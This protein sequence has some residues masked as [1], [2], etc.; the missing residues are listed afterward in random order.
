MN[1]KTIILF[2]TM[3][4]SLHFAQKIYEIPSG[5]E[6]NIIQLDVVNNAQI[7]EDQIMIKLEERPDWVDF[8][9]Q[10]IALNNILETANFIFDIKKDAVINEES[11]LQFSVIKNGQFLGE[12]RITIKVIPPKDF[13]LYQNYPNPFNPTTTIEYS[14]PANNKNNTVDIKIVIF[15]ILGREVVTIVNQK[16]KPGNYK[17]EFNAAS[18]AGGLSSGTY[19][20]R[21]ISGDFSKTMKLV[22]LK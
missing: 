4:S 6:G 3:F 18:L 5:S 8:K 17:V 21:L 15:D 10:E 19:F 16:Q 22:L 20:Y 13:A 2:V 9:V 14:V 12:K 7:S 11:S 1:I